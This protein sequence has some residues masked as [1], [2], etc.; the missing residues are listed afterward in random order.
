LPLYL[1]VN[2]VG[3][4]KNFVQNVY[5]KDSYDERAI[6]YY[7]MPDAPMQKG[8]PVE[9]LTNYKSA[10]ESVRERKGYGQ[11]NA[12]NGLQS[13]S[14]HAT[15]LQRNFLERED[16]ENIVNDCASTKR[17]G[18]LLHSI[19]RKM[20][21]PLIELV[22]N[23]QQ[24]SPLQWVAV[25][26]IQWIISVFRQKLRNKNIKELEEK[27]ND[28]ERAYFDVVL[29]YLR[30]SLSNFTCPQINKEI[31]S[32]MNFELLE[33]IC[34]P[35]RLQLPHILDATRYYPAA[36]RLTVSLCHAIAKILILPGPGQVE[37]DVT[38]IL[39]NKFM[40]YS[41]QAKHESFFVG[42]QESNI[43]ELTQVVIIIDAFASVYLKNSEYSMQSLCG[44][45]NLDYEQANAASKSL[46]QLLVRHTEVKDNKP[47]ARKDGKRTH[48]AY[49]RAEL[50]YSGPPTIPFPGNGSHWPNGWT[51]VSYKRA[52]GATKG[53]IDM[54]WYPPE[55]APK[56]RSRVEIRTHIAKQVAR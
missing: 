22:R 53:R 45:L 35:V 39:Y 48:P 5:I 2:E 50:V 12:E 18:Y 28:M 41:L 33:E 16:I 10:Y 49:G 46:Q 7:F 24:L 44:T 54:Y 47:R 38:T 32:A 11:S 4:N 34:F 36:I 21:N 30:T 42:S 43:N 37:K 17:L 1:I 23:G 26:R 55:G 8:V 15:C 27:L 52:S 14:C 9:L 20:Y 51:Q 13:D 29:P 6:Q 19:D 40:E 25:R 3:Y 31:K 56:L